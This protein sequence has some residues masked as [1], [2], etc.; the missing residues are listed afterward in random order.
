MGVMNRMAAAAALGMA[1]VAAPQMASAQAAGG[2]VGVV[3]FNRVMTEST[4]G[5]DMSSKLNGLVQQLNAQIKPEND[6]LEKEFGDI[7]TQLLARNPAL[8]QRIDALETKLK[9]AQQIDQAQAQEAGKLKQ[10]F[11]QL[12][13]DQAQK[14]PALKTR[15]ENYFKRVQALEA[16]RQQASQQFQQATASYRR[17]LDPAVE[18]AV[19][20]AMQARGTA[21]V[22]DQEAT[23]AASAS[24]DMTTDVIS[25]LN[26]KKTTVAAVAAR[27][28]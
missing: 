11:D 18:T 9:A 12:L 24:V 17:D 8:K 4:A 6:A 1:L 26:A 23:F 15:L 3:N 2:G 13:V 16:R 27:Q 20:E 22:F 14:D 10:E 5:K 7:R 19:K 28:Q 25:R 21:V